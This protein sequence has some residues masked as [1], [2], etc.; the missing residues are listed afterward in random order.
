MHILKIIL[1][2]RS[3]GQKSLQ[4]FDNLHTQNITSNLFDATVL[5]LLEKITIETH[6]YESKVGSAVTTDG[7]AHAQSEIE[8]T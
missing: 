3:G 1:L 5:H 4:P 8:Q 7:V 6:V 2:L